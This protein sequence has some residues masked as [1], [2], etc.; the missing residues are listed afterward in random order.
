MLDML[1]ILLLA[2]VIFGP[3]KL[4][5]LARQLGRYRAQFKQIQHELMGQIEAEMRTIETAKENRTAAPLTAS[6]AEELATRDAA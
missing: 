1:F 6:A 5:Q 3:E 4:P 2:L